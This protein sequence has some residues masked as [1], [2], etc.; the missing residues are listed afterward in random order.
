LGHGPT[1]ITQEKTKEKMYIAGGKLYY[2][3]LQ[4]VVHITV[5]QNAVRFTARWRADRLY[6]TI[7]PGVTESK[8][9]DVLGELTPRLQKSAPK[10]LTYSQGQRMD[11]N[12]FAVVI[13]SQNNQPKCVYAIL[14]STEDNRPL[15]IIKVWHEADFNNPSVTK[16]IG[17][18]LCH[19]AQN[20]APKLLIPHAR[21]LSQNVGREPLGW[22]ISGGHRTLGTCSNRGIIKLS[23]AIIFLPQHLRD[24]VVYHE[25]AH[26]S[27]MNHSSRFHEVCNQYCNGMENQY[28]K[29]IKQFKWPFIR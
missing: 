8:L 21:E 23:Y 19:A 4:T 25:L 17:N 22:G 6:V 15:I 7:P 11:F 9:R 20:L 28:V 13:E 26:L 12:D 29:E 3:P 5:R 24:Y 18:V 1:I 14:G 27:E 10:L 16:S 2:E